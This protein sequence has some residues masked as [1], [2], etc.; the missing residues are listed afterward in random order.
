[1]DI[2]MTKG[3]ALITGISIIGLVLLGQ[4]LLSF[5][6][7]GFPLDF[8]G[9]TQNSNLMLELETL[10]DTDFRVEQNLFVNL[11]SSELSSC[12]ILLTIVNSLI[13]SDLPSL[14]R[15]I[16]PEES[17]CLFIFQDTYIKEHGVF[18]YKGK[19]ILVSLQSA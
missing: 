14:T 8:M 2:K 3:L 18:F 19:Y 5:S 7:G 4:I 16:L 13:S 9:E 10:S 12:P 17:E 11:S 15:E 1:M 6:N